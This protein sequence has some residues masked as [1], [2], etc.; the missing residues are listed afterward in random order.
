MK[1]INRV[2]GGIFGSACGDSLNK[3]LKYLQN[4]EKYKKKCNG[5]KRYYVEYIDGEITDDTKMMLATAKGIIESPEEPTSSIGKF[6]LKIYHDNPQNLGLTIRIAL[7]EYEKYKD[8]KK[9]SLKAH[10]RLGGRSAG[11]GSLM[12]T[13]PIA[14][15]YNDLDK[16][17]EVTKKQSNLTH[18]SKIASEA[19]ILY[20]I[21][22]YRYLRGENKIGVLEDVLKKYPLY[23]DIMNI[24]ESKLARRECA[25]DTL[26]CSL[27]CFLNTE[28]YEEAVLKS[29]EIYED[30]DTIGT[31]TGGIAGVYYGYDNISENW[32]EN[33]LIKDELLMISDKISK[34]G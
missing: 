8:W 30:K 24:D 4:K 17:I 12:R 31:I 11:N 27:W 29:I 18:Y 2:R 7:A 20:N 25:V 3:C 5:I 16:M 14:L 33:L 28:S 10:L 13:L 32:K 22:I 34:V 26:R 6:F 21:L 9:A 23:K 1:P 15:Y 19:C